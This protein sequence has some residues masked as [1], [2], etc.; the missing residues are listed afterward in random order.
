[1]Q[2]WL[3]DIPLDP[4]DPHYHR[5]VSISP[6]HCPDDDDVNNIAV[7]RFG[8]T[9]IH[10]MHQ[11]FGYL[12]PHLMPTLGYP[13]MCPPYM[14][15]PFNP[16]MPYT[17]SV[18]LYNYSMYGYG[19]N[20]MHPMGGFQNAAWPQMCQTQPTLPS[21]KDQRVKKHHDK[22]LLSG[23]NL[24]AQ[25]KKEK[26]LP[27]LKKKSKLLG[28]ASIQAK[29]KLKAKQDQSQSAEALQEPTPHSSCT[30]PSTKCMELKPAGT[31]KGNV[32]GTATEGTRRSVQPIDS[33][34]TASESEE[35]SMEMSDEKS[36]QNIGR[37]TKR[38]DKPA[39]MQAMGMPK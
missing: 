36:S 30:E 26:E 12:Q 33:Q 4:E 17:P 1:M 14:M 39:S 9:V 7:P 11:P 20:P 21:E 2:Q 34:H 27:S 38:N 25:N 32:L 23:D 5:S 29:R 6:S 10:Q 37:T 8:A 22:G 13:P 16:C 19:F 24:A 3:N 31:K 35:E 18:P 28:P 15:P